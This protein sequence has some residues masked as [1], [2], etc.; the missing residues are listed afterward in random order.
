MAGAENK[1]EQIHKYINS[2]KQRA[3]DISIGLFCDDK[4]ID[5]VLYLTAKKC[6]LK[7]LKY[8]FSVQ[9]NSFDKELSKRLSV[10]IEKIINQCIKNADKMVSISIAEIKGKILIKTKID[11]KEQTRLWN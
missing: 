9:V 1:S 8:D 11:E 2:L 3:D 5:F 7:G 10:D 6:K 4:N